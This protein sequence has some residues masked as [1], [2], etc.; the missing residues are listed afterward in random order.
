M[1]ETKQKQYWRVPFYIFLGLCFGLAAFFNQFGI[2]HDLP[3]ITKVLGAI[4]FC[5][6]IGLLAD[7]AQRI[8]HTWFWLI[9]GLAAVEFFGDLVYKAGWWDIA[10]VIYQVS[11]AL[12][13]VY[14]ALFV[15]KGVELMRSGDRGV[16]FKFMVLG[17]LAAAVTGWEYVTLFPQEYDYS[18]W[19]WRALYLGI[20][21]WLLVIDWTTD[22]SKRPALRVQQQIVRVSLLLIAVWYFVRFIFK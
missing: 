18:H 10:F 6:I 16:G 19:G 14:G 21:A 7:Y 8:R 1:A 12:W 17:V 22:F 11:A 2:F 20:F 5:G 4:A 9:P 3:I 13:P 15:S